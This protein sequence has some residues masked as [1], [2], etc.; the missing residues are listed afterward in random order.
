MLGPG[1][2]TWHGRHASV[3]ALSYPKSV[4]KPRLPIMVGGNGRLVTWRLAARYADELNLDG[5]LP[6]HVEEALPVIK[7]RC[8]EE[9]RD[10]GALRVSVY[11]GPGLLAPGSDRI[12]ALRSYSEL[13]L[14]RVIVDVDRRAI[15]T[16][17]HLETLADDVVRAGVALEPA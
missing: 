12:A 11:A 4:Q 9:G 17:S 16:R 5:L 3:D 1:R 7:T 2:A 15:A 8:I 13:G 10:P 6:D 14:T